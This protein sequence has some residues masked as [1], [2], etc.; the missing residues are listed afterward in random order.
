VSSTGGKVLRWSQWALLPTAVCPENVYLWFDPV[1]LAKVLNGIH[2]RAAFPDLEELFPA[3]CQW[4]SCNA[5]TLGHFWY[6]HC[7]PWPRKCALWCTICHTFDIMDHLFM[8]CCVDVGHLGKWRRV[9]IACISDDVI[10]QFRD[11]HTPMIDFRHADKCWCTAAGTFLFWGLRCR[12]TVVYLLSIY[13]YVRSL[14]M[15]W[16][17]C[18]PRGRVKRVINVIRN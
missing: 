9:W 18:W 8:R 7:I 12:T 17:S 1:K 13:I 6:L 14:S 3:C 16:K 4:L 2:E 11:P 15:L 5:F 10:M